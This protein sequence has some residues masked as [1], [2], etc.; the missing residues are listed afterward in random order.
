[1]IARQRK[2]RQQRQKEIRQAVL[3]IIAE[4]GL[5]SLSTDALA[6][7]IGLTSGALF[8]HFSSWEAIYRDLVREALDQL[9]ATFPEGNLPPRQRVFQLFENRYQLFKRQTG[10]NWLLRSRQAYLTVPEDAVEDLKAMVK[11]T[12]RY[13]LKALREAQKQG[14]IR[15]DINANILCSILTSTFHDLW[16]QEGIPHLVAGPQNKMKLFQALET[17]VAPVNFPSK[18]R[19]LE[20]IKRTTVRR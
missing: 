18:K 12:K 11:Q 8:R 2:S 9:Q 3:K 10:L 16:G 17:L 7:E 5:I 1:M 4:K 20:K 14:E 13:L 15:S 6:R 19:H